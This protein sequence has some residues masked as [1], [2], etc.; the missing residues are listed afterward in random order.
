MA[1]PQAN[2]VFISYRREDAAGYAGRLEEALERRIGR[3]SVFRDVQDIAPGDDFVQV[4]RDRLA[5]AH[6]VLVLM[7]PR[8]AGGDAPGRRRIDDERDFV[9]LE[10]QA[11][12]E[13]GG[14]VVPL[15]LPGAT[16]PGEDALPAPLKALAQRNAL[17][18]T[19]E[20]WDADIDRLVASL[21]LMRRRAVWPWALGGAV[22]AAAAVGA[23][24][25][26]RTG[27]PADPSARLL[28]VWQA[29]VRYDWGDRYTERF[30][31]KRHAGELTGTAG[32]LDYP[33]PIEKLQFDGTN[34]RFET[35]SQESMSSETREPLHAYAAEL[36]GKPPD[37]VLVFRMQTTGGFGGHKPIEFEARRLAPTGAASAASR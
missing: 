25:L 33:R 37:E 30:E 24:C 4:I 21:G 10:V 16:M 12:L 3:H 28:G 20:H 22:V 19:D 18:I 13:S 11:A 32:F 2:R 27:P 35:H 34:L 9:R 29:D 1:D 7:G 14:R 15:L 5:G 17:T 31:F 6:G 8:W 23:L 26:W 36:R